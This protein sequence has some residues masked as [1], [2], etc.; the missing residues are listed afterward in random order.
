MANEIT[1]GDGHPATE[2]LKP[3]KVGGKT[4][5]LETAQHGNGARVTGDL[6]ITGDLKCFIDKIVSTA[7]QGLEIQTNNGITFSANNG[8]FNM[9]SEGVAFAP[10]HSAYAGM[11]LGYTRIANNQTGSS[12]SYIAMDTTLTVLQTVSGTDVSVTFIAPP[13]GKVEITM[14]VQVYASSKTVEFALSDNSTYNEIDQ[15]HS[16]D[17]GAHSADETDVNMTTVV[18]AVTGLTSGTSYTYYIAGA[19]TVSGTS[20]IRHGRFRTTGTHYPPIIVK[21]VALPATITTGE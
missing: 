7:S 17:N 3:L 21:A 19:E 9:E 4:T 6:E 1:L 8:R 12:D 10:Q 15:T 2:E 13:S 11:I 14:T 18:W 20:F 5:S 16:Y